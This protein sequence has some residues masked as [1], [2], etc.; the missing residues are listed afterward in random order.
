VAGEVWPCDGSW[1]EREGI[2]QVLHLQAES[3]VAYDVHSERA[4]KRIHTQ[5]VARGCTV[6]G[7]GSRVRHCAHS[8]T[9]ARYEVLQYTAAA[10]ELTGTVCEG[11]AGGYEGGGG[12]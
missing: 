3:N 8:V 4:K 6:R 7:Q 12:G 1:W 10:G 5:V 11:C 9:E 2:G